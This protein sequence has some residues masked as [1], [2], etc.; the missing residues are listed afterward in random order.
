MPVMEHSCLYAVPFLSVFR[1][2]LA[3]DVIIYA[4]GGE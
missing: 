4:R 2:R 3:A 1:D